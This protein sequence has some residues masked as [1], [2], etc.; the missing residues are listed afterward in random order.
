MVFN[1][2]DEQIR[3]ILERL[4]KDKATCIKY[5]DAKQLSRYKQI[6]DMR[7]EDKIFIGMDRKK[8]VSIVF[9]KQPIK[10]KGNGFIL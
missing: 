7:S 6:R 5:N 8:K 10:K 1:P 3:N 9:T 2:K 4:A